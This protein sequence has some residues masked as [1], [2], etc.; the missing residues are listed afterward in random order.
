MSL[1]VT[2]ADDSMIRIA[3]EHGETCT[4]GISK[5]S[6][7][8]LRLYVPEELRNMGIGKALLEGA[9][10]QTSAL[11]KK[12]LICDTPDND[13]MRGFFSSAGYDIKKGRPVISVNVFEVINSIGV[14]K[15]LAMEF[16]DIET[17][18]LVNLM[19]FEMADVINLLTKLGY[20]ITNDDLVR[21]ELSLSSVA[22][23]EQLRPQAVLL[24]SKDGEEIH[25]DLM[26]GLSRSRPQFI[27]AVC[28]SF[29]RAVGQ[30]LLIEEL[31]EISM[32]TVN[33]SVMQLLKRLLDKKAKVRTL[34][35]T[36]S[37]VKEIEPGGE[38][39]PKN[40][41]LNEQGPVTGGKDS[42]ILMNITEKGVWLDRIRGI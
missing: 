18:Y 20:P 15:S 3:G 38:G 34:F 19:D 10:I 17:E 23:D 33:N 29:I 6:A 14:Q 37:A 24:A 39:L 8:I 1:F 27:L 42:S 13:M 12:S 41:S 32:Y 16:E 9:A 28:Q 26:L 2:S 35:G 7:R 25:V 21:Y 40:M 31:T 36:I 11:G 5:D 4:V 22:Y 30:R